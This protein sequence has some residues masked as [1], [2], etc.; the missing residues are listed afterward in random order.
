MCI[1]QVWIVWPAETL[2][3]CFLVHIFPWVC[4]FSLEVWITIGIAIWWT[5]WWMWSSLIMSWILILTKRLGIWRFALFQCGTLLLDIFQLFNPAQKWFCWTRRF[6]SFPLL[7]NL[8]FMMSSISGLCL[9]IC[10]CI[11]LIYLHFLL[12]SRII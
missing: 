11:W 12:L 3:H 1:M 5:I 4:Y 9:H 8:W 10:F 6:S 7:Y 2:S